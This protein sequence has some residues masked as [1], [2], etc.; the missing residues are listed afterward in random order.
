MLF[1]SIEV[2]IGELLAF[3]KRALDDLEAVGVGKEVA[4]RL[5]RRA[6]VMRTRAGGAVDDAVTR[7][8]GGLGA[9]GGRRFLVL[10]FESGG[11]GTT[12]L[13]VDA[14]LREESDGE[15]EE[16]GPDMRMSG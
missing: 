8:L 6:G 16:L 12:G 3:P 2:G 11:R 5:V 4:D 15:R 9:H 7:G 1:T 10:D 14:K 13:E